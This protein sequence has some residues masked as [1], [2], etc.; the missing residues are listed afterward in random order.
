MIKIFMFLI[1]QEKTMEIK[2]SSM[3]AF[4]LRSFALA[5]IVSVF[6]TYTQGGHTPGTIRLLGVGNYFQLLQTK[7][8]ERPTV[9]ITKVGNDVRNTLIN[10]QTYQGRLQVVDV[11]LPLEIEVK[12][13]T[14]NAGQPYTIVIERITD[15]NDMLACQGVSMATV[16]ATIKGSLTHQE[17]ICVP[18][19][20][21]TLL[22]PSSPIYAN[23]FNNIALFIGPL[24][25]DDTYNP[26]D[27]RSLPF[28]FGLMGWTSMV[29]P[30]NNTTISELPIVSVTPP[31]IP[32]DTV[33]GKVGGAR[34]LS[35]LTGQTQNKAQPITRSAQNKI[36]FEKPLEVLQGFAA[37]GGGVA[38]RAFHLSV[39][40]IINDSDDVIILSRESS[41]RTL[42]PFNISQIVP[43]RAVM[44]Y[45][46]IWVPK[47]GD[48]EELYMAGHDGLRIAALEKPAGVRAPSTIA[49]SD[50]RELGPHNDAQLPDSLKELERL[51]AASLTNV[52]TDTAAELLGVTMW[53]KAMQS[54]YTNF[55][56]ADSYYVLSTDTTDKKT[57]LQKYAV[58]GNKL[59]NTKQISPAVAYDDKG[60][61]RY[62]SI[63][64]THNKEK[65]EPFAVKVYPVTLRAPKKR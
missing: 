36:E 30:W 15:K 31:I 48:T 33:A 61:P 16:K 28:R 8:S 41:N 46:L 52:V 62:V 3:I 54:A 29:A 34:T 57:Y 24:G 23:D 60:N 17:K 6:N 49:H 59:E 12:F 13:N 5:G 45:A 2:N 11:P 21:S 39:V 1:K 58:K 14:Y 37:L 10:P 9:H 51:I 55:N 27:V 43:P 32:I 63:H 38:P 7:P 19:S 40:D 18:L 44:P 42:A 25:V 26:Q 35:E 64:I 4:V 47:V 65:N 22:S 50:I 53:N 20:H 56:A